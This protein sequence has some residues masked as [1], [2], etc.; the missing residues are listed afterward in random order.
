MTQQPYFNGSPYLG[1]PYSQPSGSTTPSSTDPGLNLPW[2]GIG[3]MPAVQRFFKKY[4]TFTGR[5]SRGE[6]WWVWLFNFGIGA[7]LGILLLAVGINWHAYDYYYYYTPVSPYTGFGTFLIIL[8]WIYELGVLIPS[9]AVGVRR[10]HDINKSG[11]WYC[12]IFIPAVG[13]IWLIVLMATQTYPGATQWDANSLGAYQ[14]PYAPQQYAPAYPPQSDPQ[15]YVPQN[16][17][18]SYPPQGAA[19]PPQGSAYPPQSDPQGYVPQNPP[20]SYPPQGSPYPP[21]NYPPQV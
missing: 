8:M 2:Y 13:P 19:Y 14:Q 4:V 6:Y 7:I 3:F 9:I 10:L 21:Q 15:G 16:P 12:V 20:Q 11:A 1:S 18:Q 17:P 5:A